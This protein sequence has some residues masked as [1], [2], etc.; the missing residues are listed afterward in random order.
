[1]CPVSAG[2]LVQGRVHPGSELSP[3][4]LMLLGPGRVRPGKVLFHG[5]RVHRIPGRI[6]PDIVPFHVIRVHL[7]PGRVRLGIELYYESRVPLAQ[8]RVHP[9]NALFHG[10]PTWWET[11]P[12]PP[13]HVA[14]RP[15]CQDSGQPVT[16]GEL[17][18]QAQTGRAAYPV[19]MTNTSQGVDPHTVSLTSLAVLATTSHSLSLT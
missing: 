5:N 7:R 8:G 1:M 19:P 12:T 17:G 3:E 4:D 6:L 2:P 14:S 9:G 11:P 13:Y 10:Y 16:E 15:L 18:G